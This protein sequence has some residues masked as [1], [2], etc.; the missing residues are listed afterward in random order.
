MGKCTQIEK[1]S[2]APV[3]QDIWMNIPLSFSQISLTCSPFI[4]EENKCKQK[5]KYNKW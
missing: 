2:L 5:S 4:F 1:L 3:I